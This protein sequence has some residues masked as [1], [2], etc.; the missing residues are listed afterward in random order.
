VGSFGVVDAGPVGHSLAGMIDAE[1]EGFVEQ[2]V[3]HP[4][5][6]SLAIAVLHR[7][8]G[9][10]MVPLHLRQTSAVFAPASCSRR[11]AMICPSVNFDLFMSG[12]LLGPDTGISWASCRRSQHE[13]LNDWMKWFALAGFARRDLS[14]GMNLSGHGPMLQ[15]AA[16]GLGV[17]LGSEL[18]A[19]DLLARGALVRVAGMA[20]HST[21]NFHLCALR[22]N[23][24]RP[25]VGQ[26]WDWF[27]TETGLA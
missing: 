17:C 11:I 18:L 21:N 14:R 7:L 1:E 8:A 15:A 2:F 25:A 13:T 23:F 6:E 16:S 5:V 3:A 9:R 26:V 12:P 4:A 27:A 19:T 22:R 20:M 10:D 24:V